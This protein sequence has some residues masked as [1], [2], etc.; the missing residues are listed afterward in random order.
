M[1]KIFGLLILLCSFFVMAC[2]FNN[3]TGGEG[4]VNFVITSDQINTLASKSAARAGGEEQQIIYTFVV[5][6]EG[7]NGYYDKQIE[8]VTVT[9][10][11][12][13]PSGNSEDKYAQL[14]NK[15]FSFENMPVN[16]TYK[17]MVDTFSLE[18]FDHSDEGGFEGEFYSGSYCFC[19]ASSG[20]KVKA[21]EQTPVSIK[22]NNA[23]DQ[24]QN[25]FNI[26]VTYQK[27][28]SSVT[29]EI[30]Y[31]DF[32][33]IQGYENGSYVSLKPVTAQF[34]WVNEKLYFRNNYDLWG[35]VSDIKIST[36]EDSHFK[37]LS[38]LYAT[39]GDN[40]GNPESEQDKVYFRNNTIDI[41]SLLLE[42]GCADINFAYTI[43]DYDYELG[44]MSFG[45]ETHMNDLYQLAQNLNFKHTSENDNGNGD[46]MWRYRTE[47]P[48][49]QF[50]EPNT[51]K[52]G[53]TLL[54]VIEFNDNSTFTSAG[55][56][57]YKLQDASIETMTTQEERDDGN[58]CIDY[59][60]GQNKFIMPCNF[61]KGTERYLQ[62]FYDEPEIPGNTENSVYKYLESISYTLFPAEDKVYVFRSNVGYDADGFMED[63]YRYEINEPIDKTLNE[64]N[65]VKVKINGTLKFMS[66]DGV[67]HAAPDGFT[68][69]G[70]LFDESDFPAGVNDHNDYFDVL[71]RDKLNS[72]TDNINNV[73]SWNYSS[74]TNPAFTFAY[75]KEGLRYILYSNIRTT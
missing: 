23:Y 24:I 37:H 30:D 8:P 48:L 65:T 43:N 38:G 55:K 68:L 67:S 27:D 12:K 70:E 59:N 26:V 11:K 42:N 62:I 40:H 16:Q 58:I 34:A 47:I 9:P 10:P 45:C 61:I 29:E 66:L 57:Y 71:S 52:T 54:F 60:A 75:G 19:G 13:E 22:L 69:Y 1:K 4:S 64:N 15:V 53:D 50:Y 72:N 74:T 17:V 2:D 33:G 32:T 51:L 73:K 6:V 49:S 21:N 14:E 18:S 39:F 28:G 25:N 36:P 46:E 5:Q 41:Y 35:E 63:S 3:G 31:T 44:Y 7:S 20:I 56:L